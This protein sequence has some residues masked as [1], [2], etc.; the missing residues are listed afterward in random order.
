MPPLNKNN[1]GRSFCIQ[2]VI[3]EKRLSRFGAAVKRIMQEARE[4]ANDPSTD[5]SAAPLEDDIFV[6]TAFRALKLD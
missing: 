5:Y 4:L 3:Q 6:S 1:S 2:R